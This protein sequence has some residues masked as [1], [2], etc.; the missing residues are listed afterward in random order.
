MW[1]AGE[2]GPAPRTRGVFRS[3]TAARFQGFVRGPQPTNSHPRPCCEARLVAEAARYCAKKIKRSPER[4]RQSQSL[5]EFFAQSPLAKVKI[6]LRRKPD[7][8]RKVKL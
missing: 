4:S 7:Y 1:V 6:D 3:R 8:G 5:V 2:A